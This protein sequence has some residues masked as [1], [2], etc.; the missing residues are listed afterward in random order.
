[1][2]S[3]ETV[4]PCIRTRKR[5][6]IPPDKRKKA[7]FSCDRCK[8][9][10]IACHRKSPSLCCAGCEKVGAS[11]ETTIKR[12]KKIRGP[13][14]NIGL[15]YKCLLALI[16]YLFPEI[17]V[18]NI[19]ALIDVGE[20]NGVSMPSRYGG[21]DDNELRD[22]SLL[23]TLGKLLS[24]RLSSLDL[25]A[26]IKAEDLDSLVSDLLEQEP[27]Q[28]PSDFIMT[29]LTGNKHMVGP[30]SLPALLNS[31]V[32]ALGSMFD[33]DL[34]ACPNLQ[35]AFQGELMVSSNNEPVSPAELGFLYHQ[36]FPYLD[37]ISAEEATYFT[38]CFFGN[39]HPRYPLFV[40]RIFRSSHDQFW[41]AVSYN[42]RDRYLSQH[43]I[44]SIY[45]VWLLGRL[46]N[47]NVIQRVNHG[48]VLRYLHIIKLCLSDIVLTPSIDGIRTLVLLAIYMENTMRKESAYVL[49]QVATRHCITLGLHR[50]SLQLD[51]V[52]KLN[53][54]EL[55]RIWWTVYAL[56]VS[57]SC[58]IGR[59]STVHMSDVI[60]PYPLCYDVVPLAEYSPAFLT[61]LDLAKVMHEL[62]E[63]RQAF[64][65]NEDIMSNA[66]LDKALVLDEKLSRVIQNVDPALMDL[67]MISDYK[68][69][70]LLRYHHGHLAILLPFFSRV[71]L[72]SQHSSNTKVQTLLK[73][74]LRLSIAISHIVHASM[75]SHML[76]GTVHADM[77][78]TFQA[79]MGLLMGYCFMSNTNIASS[80]NLGIPKKEIED[81]IERI[82][83]LSLSTRGMCQGTNLKYSKFID[84][85]IE[86]YDFLQGRR[87]KSSSSPVLYGE[88]M[89]KQEAPEMFAS[90][91]V[92]VKLEDDCIDNGF[93]EFFAQ[94]NDFEAQ[95][96]QPTDM[97]QFGDMVFN[98]GFGPGFRGPERFSA[99]GILP[100]E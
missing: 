25:D 40:E 73:Q 90:G 100:S 9:R 96:Y 71:A 34:S 41:A 85:F 55:R 58:L 93:D 88:P 18:N 7:S 74:G 32:K 12:K 37:D 19:D 44:C 8:I 5:R 66:N 95:I 21:K 36:N 52:D 56:E 45:M 70:L 33:M 15:H 68:V 48:I 31:S 69:H 81:A 29:D 2:P 17:D 23:I 86:G 53:V 91:K 38:D 24:S 49:I 89:S 10:K 60:V 43:S 98:G 83:G 20:R 57:Y 76:N 30:L 87:Q 78:Y 72:E 14:E 6:L 92:R 65:R 47:P 59:S 75:S 51:A 39:V 82:R 94:R 13:I 11:C 22:L 54:E 80:I 67:S 63:Y 97:S 61:M 99:E 4:V 26:D 46:F 35:R 1:M 3:D 27:S 84:S 42:S 62:L 28:L 79:T 77:F 64:N 16:Q 50:D